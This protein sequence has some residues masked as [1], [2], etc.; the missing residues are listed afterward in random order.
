M[1]ISIIH[2]ILHFC[3]PQRLYRYSLVKDR[4]ALEG[5]Y[6][7]WVS[8]LTCAVFRELY[9]LLSCLTGASLELSFRYT[10]S[11]HT[12]MDASLPSQL[13]RLCFSWHLIKLNQNY[14]SLKIPLML[15]FQYTFLWAFTVLSSHIFEVVCGSLNM[16]LNKGLLLFSNLMMC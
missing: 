4:S 1:N 10:L 9:L 8:T 14:F 13:P 6:L 7:R 15:N 11:S 16:I 5:Q 12:F 2:W 3:L